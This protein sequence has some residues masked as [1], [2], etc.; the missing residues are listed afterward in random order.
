MSYL[1]L[2]R[3]W[4]PQKFEDIV[5]Q[6]FVQK[7]L[8]NAISSERVAHAFLFSGAR[9]VG[10]T[11][12]ARILAKSLNCKQGPTTSPCNVCENCKEIAEGNSIDVF[13][14]DGA[15]NRGIDEI[16]ELR[17]NIKY[18]PSKSNYKIYIV[19]EV[20]MLTKEAF[21]ALL[22]T[23]EE[24]PKHVVFIFATTEPHKIPITI[25]SRCQRYDFK[26][27]SLKD[28]SNHLTRILKEEGIKMSEA[29]ILQIAKAANG[30]MRDS[31][32]I[33]DQIISYGGT[34]ISDEAVNSI[35]G[36]IDR[37]LIYK[38]VSAVINKDANE[39]LKVIQSIY[40]YGYDINQFC[41]NILEAFR[42][43]I[44]FKVSDNPKEVIELSDSELNEIK[45]FADSID[46]KEL[47]L[48]YNM[49]YKSEEDITKSLNPKMILEMTILKMIN[50]FPVV[51][52]ESIM[53]KLKALEKKIL[54]GKN[55]IDFK[56]YSEVKEDDKK[57]DNITV[58][59]VEDEAVT[60]VDTVTSGK[61]KGT[62]DFLNYIKNDDII[63]YSHIASLNKFEVMD[64]E[65]AI[66]AGN[67]FTLTQF[68]SKEIQMELKRLANEFYKRNFTI[69]IKKVFQKDKNSLYNRK[70]K[71]KREMILDGEHSD[72]IFS[73][74]REIFEGEL[75]DFKFFNQ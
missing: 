60:P 45:A 22:K 72:P 71:T 55:V 58:R 27:I 48:I 64:D 57:K 10:K 25:L 20:H 18:F 51:P 39:A 53:V 70:S 62:R 32:S 49:L 28:I 68:E 52:L 1:V 19:D 67:N 65:I 37:T 47:L 43:V 29:S 35:L 2:A 8:Q 6:D 73:K 30:S 9:G 38:I 7:T 17:E 46:V 13:E 61:G 36:V 31:Q 14:I 40:D 42:D 16:R 24:P 15:S 33:L 12:T 69:T 75:I 59:P 44:A 5:G 11:S 63:L 41:F 54:H 3:K 74:A 21:N 50:R 56:S 23:L 4:R 66:A 26:K 34:D